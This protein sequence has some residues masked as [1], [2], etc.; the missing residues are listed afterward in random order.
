MSSGGI[1]HIL[2]TNRS[3][4]EYIVEYIN[5]V[6][7][8]EELETQTE[9]QVDIK[10]IRRRRQVIAILDAIYDYAFDAH[11]INETPASVTK[12]FNAASDLRRDF[13]H[14]SDRLDNGHA[15]EIM[16]KRDILDRNETSPAISGSRK[17]LILWLAAIHLWHK[18]ETF[19]SQASLLKEAAKNTGRKTASLKTQ[20]SDIARGVNFSNA[21][22]ELFLGHVEYCQNAAKEFGYQHTPFDLLLPAA[23][24]ISA[25]RSS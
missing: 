4:E 9:Y 1:K 11:S 19:P 2:N 6:P 16:L 25:G 14:D 13:R 20:L 3:L 24:A 15:A 21:E 10:G 8:A 18:T 5:A 22:Q 23:R 17:E 7:T 12:A